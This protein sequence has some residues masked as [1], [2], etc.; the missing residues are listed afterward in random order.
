MP[1]ASAAETPIVNRAVLCKS[2]F[3]GTSKKNAYSIEKEKEDKR[4]F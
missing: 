3:G 2:L 4:V 1:E